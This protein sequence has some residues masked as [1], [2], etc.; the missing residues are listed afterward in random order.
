MTLEWPRDDLEVS[1]NEISEVLRMN[2]SEN[3]Y[4]SQG[5]NLN[6]FIAILNLSVFAVKVDIRG[7]Y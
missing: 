7:R 2:Q 3:V 5:T 1:Q 6:I 4:Y